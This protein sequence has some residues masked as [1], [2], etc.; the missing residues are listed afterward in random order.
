[1]GYVFMIQDEGRFIRI[2]LIAI[3]VHFLFLMGFHFL[4]NVS[5]PFKHK[6]A[7]ILEI[8]ASPKANLRAP[9]IAINIAPQLHDSDV[10]KQADIM[11]S[12]DPEIP[13]SSSQIKGSVPRRKVIS[14]ASHQAKDA[15]YLANW[16][17]YIEKYGNDHYP[18]SILNSNL[19]GNVRLL[20]AVNRDGS[21]NSVS[22]RQSSG[23][24]T[25]DEAAVNIVFN[26]APFEPLPNNLAED[27]D[28]LEIIRTWQF[29]GKLSTFAQ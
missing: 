13:K 3:L 22:V 29:R 19:Q 1:M 28:V 17:N 14:A 4:P 9:K 26:A 27:I 5:P 15:E 2:L 8:V 10:L 18:K 24:P 25:L 11:A 20:V 16:Q 7:S 12:A 23:I 6:I 21:L